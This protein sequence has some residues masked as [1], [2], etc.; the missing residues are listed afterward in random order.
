MTEAPDI[1]RS[2]DWV[3]A[4]HGGAGATSRDSLSAE[5]EALIR[6]D[7]TAALDVMDL[8]AAR[9]EA[10]PTERRHCQRCILYALLAF[11]RRDHDFFQRTGLSQ[12]DTGKTGCYAGS[13][14]HN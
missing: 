7:L 5:E 1:G 14:P 10:R 12:C 11:P 13:V 8:D 4:I 9:L 6:A 2:P 3:I